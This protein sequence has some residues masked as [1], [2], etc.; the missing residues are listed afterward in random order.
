[1][2]KRTLYFGN[3]AYLGLKLQQLNIK[4]ANNPMALKTVPIE[5]IGMV[6]LDHAQIT[7]THDAICALTDASAII[8]ICNAKHMPQSWVLPYAD[9]A[10][11]SKKL[12]MQLEASEPLKKQLWKQTVQCKIENQAA[13]LKALNL[14]WL[15]VSHLA[16][17]VSSGDT[18]NVEGRAAALYW[19]SLLGKSFV[20]DKEGLMPNALL[21][22]GYAILRAITARCLI[23]SGCLLAL[24]IHHR[25]QY[26]PNCLADDVM[27]PY[28]P[29][30][31][32]LVYTFI[33]NNTV[34]ENDE[35]TLTH[36]QLLLGLSTVDVLINGQKSPLLVAMQRTTASLMQCFEGTSRKIMYPD[37]IYVNAIEPF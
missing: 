19:V 18:E 8:V 10:L 23:G 21:N 36:K 17:K 5:D 11:Y 34:N 25:N 31:D 9:N 24:G 22:Y 2:I 14:K 29:V 1:M 4:L 12:K 13:L 15:P 7:I 27:E 37:L 20:R 35:L 28:R 33:K 6:V 3:P 32:M 30:I 16:A 26:N